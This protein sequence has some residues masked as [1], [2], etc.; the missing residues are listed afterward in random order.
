MTTLL[1]PR[2]TLAYL[3]YL[4]YPHSSTTSDQL[5]PSTTALDVTRPRKQDRKKG[6]VSR[7]VFLAYVLGEIG[8][9]SCRERVS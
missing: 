8:R 4:G 1:E 5:L 2:I 9:A 7:N 3:A 6:T